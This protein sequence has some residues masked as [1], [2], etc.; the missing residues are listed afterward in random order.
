MEVLILHVF[1]SISYKIKLTKLSFKYVTFFYLDKYPFVMIHKV[2]LSLEFSDYLEFS[3]GMQQFTGSLTPTYG[4]CLFSF[5]SGL[6]LLY[7]ESCI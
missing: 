2:D 3:M 5:H 7:K 4:P 1:I 6:A